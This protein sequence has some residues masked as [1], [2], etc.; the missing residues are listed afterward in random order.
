[1]KK[2]IL[3]FS[4]FIFFIGCATGKDRIKAVSPATEVVEAEGMA[5]IVNN[6][7]AGAKK[8]SLDEAMKNALGL[9]VGVYVSQEA[10]VSRAV[11]LEDNIMARTEGY[12]ERYSVLK[13]ARENDFYK[14]RIK[15]L[16]RKED[17]SAK[18]KALE[19]EKKKLGNP[20]VRL[21][22]DETVDGQP[23]A[24]RSSENE[25]KKKLT[26]EGF[27]VS[28]STSTD[29]LISGKAESSHNPGTQAYGFISYRAVLALTVTQPDTAKVIATAQE[30]TG[31]V[32]VT[33][34]AAAATALVNAARKAG[35]TLP[36]NINNYLN[37]RSVIQLSIDNIENINRLN[38]V[39]KSVRSLIEVRDC[40]V[41]DFSGGRALVDLD[42]KQGNSLELARRLEQLSSVK[43]KVNR[44]KAYDIQAELLKQ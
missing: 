21:A 6:D 34:E 7:I 43:I 13:E 20:T 23:S 40:R 16:V 22:I 14:V 25:L 41:R 26:D 32:D 39:V 5:P 2:H 31:G 38:D 1:M 24:T 4:A 12:I 28:D 35:K 29:L 44:A 3:C 36:E 37:Q 19:L 33:K 9:V 18:L 10:L 30:T 17:L 27:V 8:T 15:A 42:M 11:L